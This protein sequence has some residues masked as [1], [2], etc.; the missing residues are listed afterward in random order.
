MTNSAS[1]LFFDPTQGKFYVLLS[2]RWFTASD[3]NGPWQL[4]TDKLPP[5]FALIPPTGDAHVAL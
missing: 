3:L 1:A 5:D 2:G 4:A